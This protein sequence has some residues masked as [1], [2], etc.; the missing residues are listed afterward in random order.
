M[1]VVGR[2]GDGQ[3]FDRD[4]GDHP[5]AKLEQLQNAARRQVRPAH[6]AVHFE[7][8]A[9]GHKR[10]FERHVRAAALRVEAQRLCTLPRVDHDTRRIR[11]RLK[12]P[13]LE[14]NGV[15]AGEHEPMAQEGIAGGHQLHRP[16]VAAGE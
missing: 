9:I 7:A 1:P 16:G 6:R 15:A 8:V 4:R 2:R 5:G 11:T 13:V 12:A 14:R 10:V 3:F